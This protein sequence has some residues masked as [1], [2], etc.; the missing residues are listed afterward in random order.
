MANGSENSAESLNVAV[1]LADQIEIDLL[2]NRMRWWKTEE[3]ALNMAT[4]ISHLFKSFDEVKELF[5]KIEKNKSLCLN[6]KIK[7]EKLLKDTASY[8]RST[9]SND[10]FRNT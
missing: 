6:E 1:E 2:S 5:N 8:F 4:M 3:Q 10:D 7:K 9:T